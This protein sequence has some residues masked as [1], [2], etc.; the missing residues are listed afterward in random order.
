MSAKRNSLT[1]ENRLGLVVISGQ[2]RLQPS[3]EDGYASSVIKSHKKPLQSNLG[4]GSVG[5]YRSV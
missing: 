3:A 4:N 5:V 2:V 1:P